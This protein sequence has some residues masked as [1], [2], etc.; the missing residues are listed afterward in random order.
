[1]TSAEDG[2][3]R[4]SLPSVDRV[5][6]QSVLADVL[7]R[8][9]H[10][11]V[12]AV[13]RSE[14]AAARDRALTEVGRDI[15][16]AG[17]LAGRVRA[18][19]ARDW[20]PGPFRVI[21]A[22]GVILH[23]NVGRAPLSEAARQAVRVASGYSDLEIDLSTGSRDNRQ[24]RVVSMLT[25]LTGAEAAHVTGN[26]AGAML[27]SLSVL[28]SG[29]EVIVSRGQEVEIGGSFR[30]PEIL[31][32]SGCRLVEVGTTNR[33]RLSDYEDAV[34]PDTAA[35]LHVH[36]SNFQV[37]GFTETVSLVSLSR[38]AR[39]R[40]ILLLDDNGSG[41]LLDTVA[42]GL[43]HEPT[44][45]ES[46]AAGCDIVTFSGDKL[47]GGPQAGIILGRREL[48]G[49]LAASPL[50][51]ALR[52]DKLTLAALAATLES[53]LTGSA[54]IDLPVWK[55]IGQPLEAVRTRAEAWCRRA[56][57]FRL[58]LQ[59]KDGES[60]VGGGSLPGSTLPTV[61]IVLPASIGAE[62]LR[63]GEP[64]VLPITRDG[65]TLLD[66]RSVAEEDE[67]L[68]LQAVVAACA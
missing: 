67:E 33:T 15:P 58:P 34:G 68:L 47:L 42:F 21:N 9:Q 62:A 3:P 4:R 45:Q 24:R 54:P 44:P 5:L 30:V 2:E 12:V 32:Q 50:A 53:Y 19:L 16:S 18:R 20:S 8:Y 66:L 57:T 36:P 40:D 14:L 28:A 31:R 29:R 61:L 39:E 49:R 17:A 59:L 41:P 64:S 10:E 38:L 46:L 51:R 56:E 26:N 27:L 60:T 48:V 65:R 52:P 22:S 43:D 13:I 55:M 11:A 1:M 37:V 35:F 6:R 7:D 25:A 23:T 63:R